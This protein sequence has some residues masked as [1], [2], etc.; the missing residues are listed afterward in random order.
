MRKAIGILFAV[1]AIAAALVW[2]ISA[3]AEG[4]QRGERLNHQLAVCLDKADALEILKADKEKGFEAAQTVWNEKDK[5][6]SVP[7]V[8]P[9]VGSV[10]ASAKIS[11]DGEFAT[12]RVVEILGK[13]GVIAYFFTTLPVDQRIGD[14]NH[15][16]IKGDRN[17]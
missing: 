14:K 15:P 8:G 6:A 10:V 7:V 17:S 12:M 4:F 3:N 5:C 1:A 11:R 16:T 2:P 9:L 13:D